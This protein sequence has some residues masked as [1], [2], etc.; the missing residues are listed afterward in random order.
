MDTIVAVATPP[1]RSA[2]GIIRLSGPQS[3]EILRA[4]THDPQFTPEPKRIFLKQIFR[5][6]GKPLDSALVSYFE[7]PQSFT[8]EDVIEIS[9]HGSPVILR[10]LLDLTQ[11]LGARLAGP[12][13]FTLRACQNGKMNLSQAEAVRDVINAQ[14]DAA[15]V[16]AA[17]QLKG[18]LSSA[19][20]RFKHQLIQIIVR[21]ESA[22]EF[23]E[24]DLPQIQSEKISHNL[25]EV[26]AGIQ[27]LASTYATG[28][29]LR[30]GIK[31][32]IVG[33]P[34]VGK[35]SLFNRLLR[36]D[37]AIVT[38]IA[39]TTR[40]SITETISLQGIPVSLTD[41]AGIR[42]AGDR[43]EEIGVERT[44]R[45]MA[46]AD[47][48]IIVVDGSV[49]LVPEDLA[50]LSQATRLRRIVAINKCDLLTAPRIVSGIGGGSPVVHLSALT[51]EGL[52]K[53]STAILEAFGSV[54]SEEVGLLV[55]DSRHYDLLRRA[56]S[57]LVQSQ[58]ALSAAASEELVL[59]GLHN[60]LRFLGEI[61]GETTTE[62]I[63][64]EI[65]TTFCI[66]K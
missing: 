39:G 41:T 66:G 40:D 33:R 4:L 14:T 38:D 5:D 10:L 57:W 31:A 13:E 9:C 11:K 28:H 26:L 16:Q 17:R 23:V 3:L 24:D 7:G 55:T 53:L 19:L 20:Q 43:I 46:D 63:L 48:L 2:I 56:E 12:G 21:L 30:D 15:A 60:A 50:I 18:E 45:A 52:E 22:V 32:A 61:T 49:E 36:L 65:F 6:S 29:L 47:V 58:E 34:N 44:H 37:R 62:D 8:G 27:A 42:T 35:S 59:V 64:S 54:D 1:G 51:G 25:S